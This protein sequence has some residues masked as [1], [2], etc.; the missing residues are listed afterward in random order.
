[1]KRPVIV[2]A[3][4]LL[5]LAVAAPAAAAKPVVEF[6]DLPFVE[7]FS[8]PAGDLCEF[9]VTYRGEGVESLK[10]WFPKGADPAT[11]PW[12]KGLYQRAGTDSFIANG[13]AVSGHYRFNSHLY[14][15]VIGD[16]VTWQETT[17]GKYWG[18]TIPGEGRVFHEA[19]NFR[20]VVEA[21]TDD[22]E[23]WIYTQ[24]REPRGSAV[25]DELALCEA[26]A[27]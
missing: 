13:N 12:V 9:P 14:D 3:V 11:D 16:P 2:L 17:S 20:Q 8:I 18:F 22:P 27:D 15:L 19:G 25:F 7:E 10:S 5:T 24:L 6:S 1:M 4:L 26:L 23:T 21:I